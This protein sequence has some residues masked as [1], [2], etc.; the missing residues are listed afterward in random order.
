MQV[1]PSAVRVP[2]DKIVSGFDLPDGRSPTQTGN[3]PLIDKCD[4]LKMVAL[5]G[6]GSLCLY[7]S[8]ADDLAITEVMVLSCP[9]RECI[10]FAQNIMLDDVKSI[11]RR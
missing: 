2:A 4:I 1:V 7:E 5:R 10:N 8:E 9:V 3:R 6:V 11:L